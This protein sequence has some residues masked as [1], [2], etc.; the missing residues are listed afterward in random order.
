M[1]VSRLIEH[2]FWRQIGRQSGKLAPRLLFQITNVLVYFAMGL[3]MAALLFKVPLT[4][5]IATSSVIGLVIGFAVKS[6]IPDTFSGIALNLDQGFSISDFIQVINRPG[7][8]RISGRVTN[9]NWRSTYLETPEGSVMVIPNTVVSESIVLNLSKPD[10]S[11]EFEQIVTLD[12]QIPTDRALR[13]LGAAVAAAARETD[14]IWDTKARISE[15]GTLGVVYKI[16]YM[17]DPARMG[18]GKAK[19][20]ILGHVARQLELTGI[21]PASSTLVSTDIWD[22]NHELGN[23]A[24]ALRLLKH[25]SLFAKLPEHYLALLAQRIPTRELRTGDPLITAGDPGESMFVLGEGLVAVRIDTPNG[26]LD[27]ATLTPGNFF[28]EMSLLTGEP[29]SASVVA[30]ADALAF[31]IDKSAILPLLEGNPQAAELMSSA[32]AARRLASDAASKA[33]RPDELEEAHKSMSAKILGAMSNFFGK[34]KYAEPKGP[35]AVNKVV[36]G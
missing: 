30:L 29:R 3:C 21:T 24:H 8:I 9:I 2:L 11:G 34:S 22:C 33:K 1:F 26:E 12:F 25:V 19:H 14:A 32:A 15:I 5:A 16:K 36:N 35:R 4:G 17:L 28:G 23:A 10:T 13:V 18:P 27:V 6:L 20:L 31:E 7:T